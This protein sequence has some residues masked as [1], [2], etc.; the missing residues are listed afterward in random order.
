MTRQTVLIHD[1]YGMHADE[2]YYNCDAA[3][4]SELC[5]P[6]VDPASGAVIGIIDAE[7]WRKR[8][9][10]RER[11]A[12]VLDACRQ[13]GERGLFVDMLDTKA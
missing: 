1:V 8:H 13:L 6:I 10:T 4:L 11:L 2:P 12:T 5:T 7:A 9:F 3:V